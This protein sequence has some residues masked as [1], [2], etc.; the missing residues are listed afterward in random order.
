[1]KH[2][3]LLLDTETTIDGLVADFGAIVCDKKG[4]VLTQC[5]VLTGD[6]FDNRLKHP[7]FFNEDAGPLWTKA[8]LDRRYDNYQRMLDCGTRMLAS[9]PAINSWLAKAAHVYSPILT[10]YNLSFDVD[11]CNNSGIDLSLFDKR[12]CLWHTSA[13]LWGQ[14]RAY[15]AMCLETLAFN[16]PTA[17]G[18]MS[19]KTNAETMARFV[20]GCPELPDEPH[21]ALEDVIQYELPILRRVL[22]SKSTKWILDSSFGFNWRDYQVKDGFMPI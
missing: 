4:N 12:F 5:A 19:Y 15:R 7:L 20:T 8:S 2:Y 14:S 16:S 17:L 10:A 18:N 11:K 3:Y 1:M 21:T 13:A 9:V 22:K 6:I